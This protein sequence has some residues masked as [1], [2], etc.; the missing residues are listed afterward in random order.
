M[1]KLKGKRDAAVVDPSQL[2]VCEPAAVKRQVNDLAPLGLMALKRAGLRDL[3]HAWSVSVS[4]YV[5]QAR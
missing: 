2:D 4:K 5:W 3:T 1:T